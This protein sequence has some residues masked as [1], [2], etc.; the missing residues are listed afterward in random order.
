MWLAA[1]VA[2]VVWCAAA[3]TLRSVEA[4]T[5]DDQL[6]VY[7]VGIAAAAVFMAASRF[8]RRPVV[9]QVVEVGRREGL[10]GALGDPRLRIGFGAGGTFRAADGSIVVAGPSQQSTLLDLR[11]DE[12]PAVQVLIVHRPGLLDDPLMRTD[13]EAAARLLADH[14]R[15]IDEVE[16]HAASVEASR[17]ACSRQSNVR[18]PALPRTSNSACSFISTDCWMHSTRRRRKPLASERQ[19]ARSAPV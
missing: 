2:T 17:R 13:V 7:Q 8:D 19:P 5:P 18:L 15:L 4:L 1:I 9:E 14:H 3:S 10:G 12:G 11:D 16:Q 6:L